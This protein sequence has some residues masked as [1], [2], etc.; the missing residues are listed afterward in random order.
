MYLSY[1][2]LFPGIFIQHFCLYLI[3]QNLVIWSFLA[4]REASKYNL[5]LCW[6][7]K[8]ASSIIKKE[9]ASLL[10]KH[11]FPVDP[12]IVHHERWLALR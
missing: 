11:T 9:D 4:V 5:S 10:L 6:A 1:L 7:D 12:L 2:R 3:G 8:Y